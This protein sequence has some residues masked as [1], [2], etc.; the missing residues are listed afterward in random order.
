MVDNLLFIHHEHMGRFKPRTDL[1]I[2]YSWTNTSALGDLL[3]GFFDLLLSGFSLQC[4][5]ASTSFK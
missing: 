2:H 5:Q 4:D 3:G 1:G